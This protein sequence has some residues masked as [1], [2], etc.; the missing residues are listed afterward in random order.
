MQGTAT[1]ENIEEN[2]RRNRGQE[3]DKNVR[4]RNG[5]GRN[6]KKITEKEKI[7]K[8]EEKK[9]INVISSN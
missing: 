3:E 5:E 2:G 9:D 4:E 6:M 8:R 1:E 7:E